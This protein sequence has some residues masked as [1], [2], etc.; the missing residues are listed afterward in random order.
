VIDSISDWKNE[1]KHFGV[2]ADEINRL[3]PEI[4]KR[5]GL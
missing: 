5:L 3:A 4:K 2:P 1:F